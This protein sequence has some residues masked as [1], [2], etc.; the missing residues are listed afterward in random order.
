[1]GG[2]CRGLCGFTAAGGVC[3]AGSNCRTTRGEIGP[4]GK[5][6][7]WLAQSPAFPAALGFQSGR[8]ETH[9]F[10]SKLQPHSDRLQL[11]GEKLRLCL[12]LELQELDARASPTRLQAPIWPTQPRPSWH[13]P[14]NE[15]GPVP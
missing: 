3:S 8:G 15:Q 5:R 2:A 13:G 1:M 4:R 10:G 11:G 9:E 6:G 7:I 12:F 14:A